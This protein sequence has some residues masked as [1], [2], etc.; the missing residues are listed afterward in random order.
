MLIAWISAGAP[1]KKEGRED[2]SEPKFFDLVP[3]VGLRQSN[4]PPD[5]RDEGDNQVA[6]GQQENGPGVSSARVRPE[7]FRVHC[8]PLVPDASSAWWP[9]RIN[10][11]G[12]TLSTRAKYEGSQSPKT[13][14]HPRSQN[15]PCGSPFRA[16]PSTGQK[17]QWN[18]VDEGRDEGA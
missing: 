1:G 3:P 16:W 17:V 8:E 11:S 15:C 13:I 18:T 4:N 9:I 12:V 7:V 6:Q 5:I 10:R 14:G 2:Q